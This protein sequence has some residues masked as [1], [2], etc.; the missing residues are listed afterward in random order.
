MPYC[1]GCTSNC[2]FLCC[3]T[4]SFLCKPAKHD[5]VKA[6]CAE[7]VFECVVPNLNSF[8][9]YRQCC[10]IEVVCGWPLNSALVKFPMSVADQP[11]SFTTAPSEHLIPYGASCCT[12]DS[13]FLKFPDCI[14]CYDKGICLVCEWESTGC[15]PFFLNPNRADK[16]LLCLCQQRSCQIVMPYLG[17]KREAQ[18]FCCDHRAALPCDADV[19]CVCMPIMFLTAVVNFKPFFGCF[20]NLKQLQEVANAN[21]LPVPEQASVAVSTTEKQPETNA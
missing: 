19:P 18:S 13:C 10:C 14:G 9:C 8:K 5:R 7:D 16:D 20:S 6:V 4:N 2:Q 11:P 3:R 15:K 1:L 17:C 12:I 21:P